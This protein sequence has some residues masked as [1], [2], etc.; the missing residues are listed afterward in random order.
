MAA[1]ALTVFVMFILSQMVL[2]IQIKR[3][4]KAK[5]YK[6]ITKTIYCLI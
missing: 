3:M 4:E 1:I 6:E 2:Y 5:E